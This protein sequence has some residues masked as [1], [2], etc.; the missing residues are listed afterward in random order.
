MWFAKAPFVKER[1]DC[2]PYIHMNKCMYYD[3]ASLAFSD[4]LKTN[5]EILLTELFLYNH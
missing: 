3:Y 1:C 5:N 2:V 4:Y